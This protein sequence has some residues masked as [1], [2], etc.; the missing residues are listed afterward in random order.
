MTL[1]RIANGVFHDLMNPITSLLISIELKNSTQVN[2]ISESSKELSEF[3][4]VIQSQLKN[5]YDR[6]TFLISKII[7]DSTVLIKYKALMNNVRIV[8]VNKN[9]CELFGNKLILIRAILNL[10]NNAIESYERCPREMQDVIISFYKESEYLN[11]SIKDFGCG[12]STKD[13]KKIFNYFYTN[14]SDGTGI[15]LPISYRS[16]RK[17]YGGEII[18]ESEYGKG[19]NFIIKIPLKIS[20]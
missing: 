17:E 5:N 11:I 18:I 4:K 3:L 14:K 9:D 12:I 16:I 7:N 19:S 13:Q 1:G 10:I 8:T 15:G 2:D 20:I 6:E